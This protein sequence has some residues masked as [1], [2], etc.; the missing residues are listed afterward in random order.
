MHAFEC[1]VSWR[2]VTHLSITT[3]GTFGCRTISDTIATCSIEAEKLC[4]NAL[5]FEA[6]WSAP[7][8]PT[9]CIEC[10]E[11]SW[12]LPPEGFI[13]MRSIMQAACS[14]STKKTAINYSYFQLN[15]INYLRKWWK[16]WTLHADHL[17]PRSV[18]LR[19]DIMY[20][21]SHLHFSAPGPP[22]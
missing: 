7:I 6:C 9:L 2:K 21:S 13:F 22:R 14:I 17:K 12:K 11:R 19:S 4:T 10:K 5:V 16:L 1:I 20:P 3:R 15:K 18:C 8:S